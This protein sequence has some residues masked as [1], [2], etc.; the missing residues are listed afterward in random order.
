MG[1]RFCFGFGSDGEEG[2]GREES[3]GWTWTICGLRR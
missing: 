1:K 2:G 3:G